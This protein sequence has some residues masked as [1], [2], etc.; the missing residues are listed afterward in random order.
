M[1]ERTVQT[2]SGKQNPQPLGFFGNANKHFHPAKIIFYV[3][4]IYRTIC[5]SLE[6]LYAAGEIRTLASMILKKVAGLA[7]VDLIAG[8]TK[9]LTDNQLVEIETIIYRLQQNEP[10][11]YICGE[12]HF[13]G[14]TFLLNRHTLIPRPETEELVDWILQTFSEKN[15]HNNTQSCKILDIGTG[16]G[17]IAVALAKFMPCAEVC[18]CD[19][20]NEALLI[21][22]K[23]AE[24]NDVVIHFKKLN[25]LQVDA[26]MFEQKFDI[27]VSNPPY[28]AESEKVTMQANVL[29]YE[30]EHALFVPDDDTLL[31][32]RKIGQISQDILNNRGLLYLETSSLRGKETADLILQMG[33]EPVVLR[34]DIAGND[35][36]IQAEKVEN[37]MVG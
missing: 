4:A 1:G 27:V 30:P 21:A 28:I 25:I 11:Q 23:N 31:F 3:L 37:L 36:M 12:A 16:S 2:F 8:K 14:M 34:K 18:A 24:K 33:F 29:E 20:S 5:Q 9:T 32:Y 6:G 19:I 22:K 10:I 17:C 7:L 26:S 13:F 35:R 15:R